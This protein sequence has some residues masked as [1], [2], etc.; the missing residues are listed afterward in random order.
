MGVVEG[1]LG[2][3]CVESAAWLPAWGAAGATPPVA[4]PLPQTDACGQLSIPTVATTFT[5]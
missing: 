2:C 5:V 4:S 1:G 3:G